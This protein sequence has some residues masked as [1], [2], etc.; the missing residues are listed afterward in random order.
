MTVA[1]IKAEAEVASQEG[2]QISLIHLGKSRE[3]ACQ[4]AVLLSKNG[5]ISIMIAHL[6]RVHGQTIRA[7][8]ER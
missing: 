1:E 4:T 3:A 5:R 2:T 8:L 7:A 6:M